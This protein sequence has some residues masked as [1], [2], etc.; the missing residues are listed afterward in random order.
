MILRLKIINGCQKIGS[1]CVSGGSRYNDD[2]LNT[3]QITA[4]V[5]TGKQPSSGSSKTTVNNN[6]SLQFVLIPLREVFP[7]IRFSTVLQS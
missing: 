1:E 3:T 4:D 6:K 2:S 5:M 7:F